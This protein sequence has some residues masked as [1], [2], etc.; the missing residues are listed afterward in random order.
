MAQDYRLAGHCRRYGILT[1]AGRQGRLWLVG[2]LLACLPLVTA[3]QQRIVSVSGALTEIVYA[4]G[5]GERLVGVD[6]TSTW[7]EA[8]ADLPSVGYQRALS[9]EGVISLSPTHVL[10]TDDAGPPEVLAHLRSAQVNLVEVVQPPSMA[11]IVAKIRDVARVLDLAERGE[12][13]VEQ[14]E[15]DIDRIPAAS[16]ARPKV[17]FLLDIGRG[18]PVAAGHSTLADAAIALAGG[19]NVFGGAF[20]GFRAVGPESLIGAAPDVILLTRRTLEV[21]GDEAGVLGLPGI[22][23]TPAGRQRRI[24]AMDGLYLLGFG[25]RTPRA[26]TE[27]AERWA[28]LAPVVSRSDS[29]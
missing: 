9:A 17:V 2:C 24:V 22:A 14:V 28:P 16:P 21:L 6:T 18:A 15:R 5:A 7:P 20:E 27:L 10:L 25:P 19:N 4:L 23:Q 1:S 3:A 26:I 29:R 12:A 13:L 11:G 8:T